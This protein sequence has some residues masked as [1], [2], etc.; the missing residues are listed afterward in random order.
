M[1]SRPITPAGR[2]S[3]LQVAPAAVEFDAVESGACFVAAFSVRNSSSRPL[4]FRLVPP[5][6]A[7]P[8]KVLSRTGR[9]LART[10]NPTIQLP[11]GLSERFDVAFELQST[12]QD[13]SIASLIFHDVLLVKGEDESTIKVPLMARR[14]GPRLEVAPTFCDFGFLVLNQRSTQFVE[15]KNTGSRPGMFELEVLVGNGNQSTNSEE[16]SPRSEVSASTSSALIVASPRQGYLAAQ[17]SI[18]IKL[19]ATASSL[20]LFRALVRTRIWENNRHNPQDSTDFDDE[21]ALNSTSGV[22]HSAEKFIDLSGN[23]VEHTVELLLQQSLEPV[24]SIHFGSLFSG[25]HKSIESVLQNNGPQPLHFKISITLGG[26]SNI[27]SDQDDR[28]TFERRKE[29]GVNPVE[30]RVEPFTSIP[31]VFTFRPRAIDFETLQCLERKHQLGQKGTAESQR[32]SEFVEDGQN[33]DDPPHHQLIPP[34]V[35]SAFVSIQCADLQAQNLTFEVSGRQYIPRLSISPQITVHPNTFDFGDV[36]T[37]DRAD[38]IVTMKNLSGLP[39]HFSLPKIAHFSA[40]PQDGRLDVLQ[41]QN[42]VLSFTPT[43]LGT[44]RS[45]MKLLVCNN[46]LVVPITVFGRAAAVGEMLTRPIVGGTTALPKDFAPQYKFLL[47]D[48]AK[49]TKGQFAKKFQRVPPY[50]VAAL[51]GTAAVDEYEFEGTNNTHLTYC[52]KELSQRADHKASYHDYLAQCRLQRL[53]QTGKRRS[54][55]LKA[56]V[57]KCRENGEDVNLGMDRPS[58]EGPRPLQLP[59]SV[60]RADDP[61][62]LRESATGGGM[63]SPVKS[64]F[65]ENKLIKKK[66][67]LQPATQAE[68]AD[69]AL[70]LDYDQLELVLSGPK[71]INFGKISVNAVVVKNLTIQNNLPQNVFVSLHLQDTDNLSELAAKTILKSQVIPPRSTAGFDLA[72]S[73]AKE[74][75]FQKEMMYS[76]N[77]IHTRQATIVAEVAPI[78]VD[79]STNEFH[80]EFSSLDQST[81]M[82]KEIVLSNTSDSTAPFEWSVP[83]NLSEGSFERPESSKSSKAGTGPSATLVADKA[84]PAT[85]VPVFAVLPANGTLDPATSTTCNFVFTPPASTAF[86]PNV[87]VERNG[88]SVYLSQVFQ[89]SITGGRSAA[90]TCKAFLHEA[91]VVSKEKKIDFGSTSAGIERTKKITLSNQT[92]TADTSRNHYRTNA[93]F[94]ASIDPPSLANSVGLKVSPAVGSIPFDD[95]VDLTLSLLAHRPVTVETSACV[96]IQIRGGKLLRI[97]ILASVIVPDVHVV[98][99]SVIEFGDVVIGVSVP[100]VISLENHS[101]IPASLVLDLKMLSDEFTVATPAK[102]LSRLEDA[103][104]IFTPIIDGLSSSP[105]VNQNSQQN[106]EASSSS[107]TKWQIN[108]PSSTTVAFH[109][110][111]TPKVAHIINQ[112]LPIQFVGI[113]GGVNS[114]GQP[115]T[116]KRQVS[117][118]AILPSLLFSNSAT[119][120]NK[121]VI[122]REGIRKVPYTKHLVLTNGESRTLRWQI[123]TTKLKLASQVA[124]GGPGIKRNGS[125]SAN[126]VIFYIAPDKGELAPQEE[127]KVRVSFLPADPVEYVEDELPLLVD[128]VFYLNLAVRGEGIHPHLSFSESK[129]TL[130]TVPLGFTSSAKLFIQSTGYDHLELSHRVPLDTTKAPIT[131]HFP[132]GK[133]LSMACPTLP[134]EIHFCSPKSVAFNARVEF[135][136]ADGNAFY[137]PVAG[138]TENCILTN[139]AFLQSRSVVHR[140]SLALASEKEKD[141]SNSSLAHSPAIDGLSA[142]A[143]FTHNSGRFPIYLL[144]NTQV[145]VEI[146]KQARQQ[147]SNQ[148]IGFFVVE[149]FH[150][151][152]DE[153][154]SVPPK[155]ILASTGSTPLFASP[156]FSEEEVAFMMQYINA[157]FL[158]TPVT[159]FPDDFANNDGKPLYDIL[160]L[161]C[162][163]KAGGAPIPRMNGTVG[164]TGKTTNKSNANANSASSATQS[165]RDLISRSTSQ[166]TE[167]LKFLKSYGAMLHD[168]QPEHLLRHEF[169]I[170]ACEDPHADPTLLSSPALATMS[171]VQ[172]RGHLER[173]WVGV[174]SAA[175]MKILYQVIKCFLL[176]RINSKNYYGQ[177]APLRSQLQ[178]QQQQRSESAPLLRVFQGSNVYS[179]AELV[180]IQWI[181][182]CA[183]EIVGDITPPPEMQVLDISH[184]LED[185]RFLFNMLAAHIPTLSTSQSEFSCFRIERRKRPM[186]ASRL[187]QN[188]HLLLSTL[189]SFGMDF[190]MSSRH[191]LTGMN[192]RE[193]VVLLL[194]LYQT[195]PQFI[196]KA[197]IQFSGSLGQ[198][199]EKSIEL[200]NPSTR[201]LRY[202]VFLDDATAASSVGGTY[203][204]LASVFNIESS[205][206]TLE[207]GKTTAFVVTCR[208][209]FSKKATARLVF[210]A[211]RDRA[212]MSTSSPSGATMVFLLESSIVSRQPVRVIQL[213]ASTY[214]RKLEEIVIEN[215]FPVNGCYKISMIQSHRQTNQST[216]GANLMAGTIGA[217][218]GANEG[219]RAI[220]E[221]ADARKRS[222]VV[223]D[224]SRKQSTFSTD[225]VPR[226]NQE[227]DSRKP[228]MPGGRSKDEADSMWCMCTQKPFFLPEYGITGDADPQTNSDSSAN[229]SESEKQATTFGAGALSIKS[230]GS[231]KMKLEFLPLLPGSYKCQIL[232]LDEKVGEFVYEIHAVAHLPPSL[233]TLEFQCEANMGPASSS[234]APATRFHFLREMTVP[235]KNPLLTRALGSLVERAN[236]QMKLRLKDGLKKCEETHHPHFHVEFN[237]PFFTAPQSGLIFS[238]SS[239]PGKQQSSSA[240][241]A[242]DAVLA[243]SRT[244]KSNSNDAV[245]SNSALST[246]KLMSLK[247]NQAH[248]STPRSSVASANSVLLDFQP[249]G[250]GVYSCKM[251]LRS[252]NTYCGS[253]DIRVY[254]LVAKVKEPNI[255]TLLEFVAPARHSIVQEIPLSNPSDTPWTLRASFAS[256]MKATMFTGPSSLQV[257]AKKT[258]SYPLT[259]SPQW[260]SVEKTSFV[261]VNPATQQQFEF[262]LSGYGEEPLA[263]D[264][265]V[266]NCQARTSITQEFNVLGFKTDPPGEQTFKVES[267]LRDVVGAP[268]IVA[269]PP[270]SSGA[271]NATGNTVLTKYPLT[272][273]PIVSGTY[274]GSITF[275]NV[276]TKEYIWYT[277]EANVNPPEPE[278]TLEMK[279][280]VRDAIGVEISLANPLDHTVTFNI[281]LQGQGLLGPTT[282][283]LEPNAAGV[284]ELVYSPL[285]VTSQTKREEGA[286]L[287]SADEIGQFW[288]RLLLSADAAPSQAIDDMQCAVGDICSQPVWLQ[289]PSDQELALQYRISNT[290]NF[291]I[292]GG[293]T[294]GLLRSGNSQP[295]HILLQPFSK[296]SVIVEYTPS[297]LSDYENTSIVFFQTGIVSDWEFTVRGKGRPPSVMKP[298]DV[299]AKVGEAAS[300]LFT[301]KN[302]F[303]ESLGVEV[304]LLSAN[305]GVEIGGSHNEAAFDMLLKKNHIHLEAF[306]HL[307]VPISFLPRLVCEAHA[308]IIIRGS[309]AYRE[310]EWHYPIHGV[311]EA[312]LH[313]RPVILA[314]QAR[315]SV[316]KKV[317]LELL[318]APAGIRVRDEVFTVEWEIDPERF[319]PLASSTAIERALSIT[320]SSNLD[321]DTD[322]SLEGFAHNAVLPYSIRF[323]PL[324][325]YRGSIY[326]LVKKKSGGRW[327]FEVVLDSSDPTVDDVITIE[328]SLNQTS[329]VTFQLRNQFRHPTAFSAEFSAGSSPAFSVYPADGTLP[330]YGSNEGQPF[331]VSF[332]PTAY[333]KMQSG[334][335][336][337]TTEEMQWTFNVKG[338]YP[339]ASSK[340]SGSSSGPNS[341]LSSSAS[342]TRLG[343]SSSSSNNTKPRQKR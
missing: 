146:E 121:C 252:H 291:S 100:R 27:Q 287:F 300:T 247:G 178:T 141:T 80:F 98:P 59:H 23:V 308:E 5:A 285:L 208:P 245:N 325:P 280:V 18:N 255:K 64:F 113:S 149:A 66:F 296:A 162:S 32:A 340:G 191:F 187:E 246:G 336:L 33:L 218:G 44:F 327:R 124:T 53:Q 102:L 122:T 96:L 270:R 190:G 160:D 173:E 89:V 230:Q 198:L 339:D 254:D 222:S 52:V 223:V 104:S 41:S 281:E 226:L 74:Q 157:N 10:A 323:E 42:I 82:M 214:E 256:E 133:V 317:S 203:A 202:D 225:P 86:P 91:K 288:Y 13:E 275:T 221:A 9:D 54:V 47:P 81:S 29:L 227:V 17:E 186:S 238:L 234:G 107:C 19:E 75:F 156:A 76:I 228:R 278:A 39:V 137:L 119:N 282:F 243:T 232:L 269:S 37:H 126:S 313:P 22:R 132:K 303:A 129:V 159:K 78:V 65:D 136:D 207:P 271:N 216:L 170:V 224:K 266:L 217:I 31:V 125:V 307:Q 115:S 253:T 295:S 200:K 219:A 199:I 236:G 6:H 306:G 128:D 197:T 322:S 163:K 239:P 134:I 257:P 166:Y 151:V 305:D 143:F 341:S 26:S 38:M 108:L 139:Y 131:V 15:V 229:S 164:A 51:N 118:T 90:V 116:I 185:G 265:I 262:E 192:R 25:E 210:Q 21:E 248:L 181:C 70:N 7:S 40:R 302:P 274:F 240:L 60:L 211:V 20:G 315:D 130:P 189:A 180:L 85:G 220:S 342:R 334:Q 117:A 193:L 83:A 147:S 172:R 272:F 297:S 194:H 50:E 34:Q 94:Y 310:L 209:R 330:Q 168:V 99:S 56:S 268:T 242:T 72:F 169:Y 333:G 286:V 328:S 144:P 201:P 204:V 145:D 196:P 337:I 311:A 290:R 140:A 213:E 93:V 30:G 331:V 309:E 319:G 48:E 45:I 101:T 244:E 105:G 237:S 343:I 250:A 2:H 148:N 150:G 264:H 153:G 316:E 215:Q 120:F 8:F 71:T 267:D 49:K 312:P 92:P 299:S 205:Q 11:A 279:T 338:T 35:L 321:A 142:V 95:S 58:T 260:I 314:C 233:E 329:S 301:F 298:I 16:H 304:K 88:D 114:I 176:Y 24:K 152:G 174:S 103:S 171:F 183:R 77:G 36:K 111:Y 4:R 161:V 283:S 46:V 110:V 251:L 67:K 57:A 112:T 293:A 231:A 63:A 273:S 106:N 73:S 332:T 87:I 292:K 175:W 1:T 14:A 241:K 135:F 188:A 55:G 109:L 127:V 318:A 277:V 294:A 62:W 261:L 179:E 177:I 69:C 324:R 326:L 335:L 123:D 276:A 182:D 3:A 284:Y 167:L 258:A 259:F 184:D 12:D 165:K 263:Q 320:P 61:L 289:N 79:L 235:V 249:K 155:Q 68:L 97:P 195:L 212:G 206:V 158:Q 138:C 43:Q 28:A 154:S 84:S